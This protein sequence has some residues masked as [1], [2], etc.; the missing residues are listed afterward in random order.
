MVEQKLSIA[1]LQN[2][3]SSN[4]NS[5]LIVEVNNH[6]IALLEKNGLTTLAFEFYE[7]NGTNGEWE[8]I[9]NATKNQ[10]KILSK[11]YSDTTVFLNNSET[12]IVPSTKYK[13]ESSE[14]YLSAIYGDNNNVISHADLINIVDN[15]VSVYRCSAS[16]NHTIKNN[17]VS[18]TYKNTY[19]KVL[20]NLFGKER[21]L[22]E[23]IKVQFYHKT[24]LVVVI[25]DNKLMLIQTYQITTAEDVI[26]YLLNIVQEFNLS[27]KNTPVE[28]SGLIDVT[29]R[30]YELLENIF[31]RLSL[32]VVANDDLFTDHI[33]ANEAHWY[34]PFYNLSV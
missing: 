4:F 29:S 20:E 7:I 22:M 12:L 19:T 26:Y 33:A 13:R 23:M 34:T 27:V 14:I 32:E 28:I 16:L 6:H 10:S 9:F 25:Y 21:M 5:K 18:F 24:M 15:P 8:G 2:Q 30:H 3:Q 1:S 11:T 31:G 17:F